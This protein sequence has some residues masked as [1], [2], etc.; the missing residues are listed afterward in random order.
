MR[1]T[2]MQTTAA[3]SKAMRVVSIGRL[4][5]PVVYGGLCLTAACSGLCPAAPAPRPRP[6]RLGRWSTTALHARG[7]GIST[8]GGVAAPTLPSNEYTADFSPTSA[9]KRDWASAYVSNLPEEDY[10]PEIEGVV[11]PELK[12][13]LF[14]NG[15]GRIERGG[16]AYS[17]IFDGDGMVTAYTIDDGKIRVKN[18]YVRTD[19]YEKEEAAGTILYRNTFGT[20]PKGGWTRN[21]FNVLQK[22][23]ANTNIIYWGGRLLT[24]WEAA[25][26]YRLDPSTLNTMGLDT[27]DGRLQPGM[28]FTTGIK[29]VDKLAVGVVGDPL[30]AHPK[31]D[32]PASA[33]LD[34][35][36]AERG[37]RLVSFG[38][39]AKPDIGSLVSGKGVFA[40]EL[41]VYEFDEEFR[42]AATQVVEIDGFAFVHDFVVTQHY[43]IWFQNPT[44]FEP[45]L[46]VAG[47]KNPAQL[48]TYDEHRPTKVHVVPRDPTDPT[49]TRRVLELPPCFVF[50]HARGFEEVADPDGQPGREIITVD[51]VVLV[52]FP[53]FDTLTR[54]RDD[55]GSALK[56]LNFSEVPI[57]QLRRIKLDLGT[58]VASQ[59]MPRPRSMEFPCCGNVRPRA[60]HRYVFGACAAAA[61]TNNPFQGI[62]RVDCETGEE[63]AHF[64][65][66]RMYTNGESTYFAI[67][68]ATVVTTCPFAHPPTNRLTRRASLRGAT[69]GKR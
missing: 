26:P 69:G 44:D 7:A 22:N 31:V 42:T 8:P 30:T 4:V 12:G 54:P 11:P 1:M 62:V 43:L 52:R 10:A 47:E 64:P 41:T 33:D 60:P 29:A 23:V 35:L 45:A 49:R 61:D 3:P 28:P 63:V 46:Y 32:E 48:I 65:G 9:S 14:R 13:T 15:P 59:T 24:L 55:D 34:P 36:D 25:Q 38:Y 17:H 66:P 6:H 2:A 27:L 50:H 56:A 53:E 51:S 68:A 5:A 39:R 20:Q 67:V 16:E 21:L 40:S 37:R 18:R 19:E 58:G 57:N